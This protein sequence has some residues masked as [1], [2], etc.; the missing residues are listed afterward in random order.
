MSERFKRFVL[1]GAC[2]GA[3]LGLVLVAIFQVV[4]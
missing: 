2:M 3:V 4:R 1:L